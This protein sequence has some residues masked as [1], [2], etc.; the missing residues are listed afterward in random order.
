MSVTY[1]IW[2]IDIALCCPYYIRI[3][4]WFQARSKSDQSETNA[5]DN[6]FSLGFRCTLLCQFCPLPTTIAKMI[7]VLYLPPP[8]KSSY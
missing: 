4:Y 2:T 7:Q 6:S 3:F 8:C 1:Q 5:Q